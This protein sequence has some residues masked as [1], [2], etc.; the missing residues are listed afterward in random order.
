MDELVLIK[1]ETFDGLPCDIYQ[2]C[3]DFYMTREQIGSALGYENPRDGIRLLHSRHKD[4]LDRFSRRVQLE[5]PS[6]GKQELVV[7][8]RRGIMEICRW[9]EQPKADEFMD[10]VWDAMDAVIAGRYKLL[11]ILEY[12]RMAAESGLLN[13]LVRKAREIENLAAGFH[14]TGYADVLNSY[15]SGLATGAYSAPA[16]KLEHKTYSASEIGGQLGVSAHKIG[17]LT[18]RHGLKTDEYGVW[19]LDKSPNSTKQVQAFRYY[20]TIIPVLKKLL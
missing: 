3:D 20:E 13:A 5:L 16:Q 14:G 7:Y 11:P 4:R 1:S 19:L 15:T 6:G 9:S 17:L 18:N 10:W 2:D 8:N 12:Q